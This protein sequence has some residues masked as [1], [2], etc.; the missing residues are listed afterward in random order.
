MSSL[1]GYKELIRKEVA[2]QVRI[3]KDKMWDKVNK[4]ML[5]KIPHTCFYC[6]WFTMRTETPRNR[7]CHYPGKINPE[8]E[9]S[10]SRCAQWEL[11][12]DPEKRRRVFFYE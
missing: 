4:E 9:S 6:R 12:P 5:K 7:C 1:K 3:E 2:K 11:E 10:F 8:K